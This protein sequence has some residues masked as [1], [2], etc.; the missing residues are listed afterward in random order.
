[1]SLMMHTALFKFE[2]KAKHMKVVKRALERVRTG[3]IL[4]SSCLRYVQ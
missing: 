1:M 4:Q 3:A 2:E